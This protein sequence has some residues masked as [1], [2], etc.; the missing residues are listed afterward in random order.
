MPRR[1][2]QLDLDLLPTPTWGGV[3]DGAGRKP[4]GDEAGQP[5]RS[6]A[7]VLPRTP[8]HVTVRMRSHVWNLR[9]RRCHARIAAALRGIAGRE[10]VRVVHF[11][12]QGNHVH[13]LAEA[14]DALALGRAL[15]IVS[16]RLSRGLNSLMGTRGRVLE[17]RYHA[18]V[19]RSPEEARRALA[20]VL[21]NHAGH[22]RRRGARVPA[23]FIDPHAS[24]TALGPDGLP[25]PVSPPRTWLLQAA[26]RG[27]YER[28]TT[29]QVGPGLPEVAAAPT[30]GEE[31][32]TYAAAA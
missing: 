22:Q 14:V 25:P 18:H 10:D 5:H 8:V 23:G 24:E 29:A 1:A 30:A 4:S 16:I 3:R 2:P 27:R 32:G 13:L 28:R 26:L 20:Y 31:P 12:V 11:S 15:R 17:D 7:A 6:R 19:L 9:T 21:D